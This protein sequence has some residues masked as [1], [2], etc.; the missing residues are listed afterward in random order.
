MG[1]FRDGRLLVE[2]WEPSSQNDSGTASA[3]RRHTDQAINAAFTLL[4]A[5]A[6]T[7]NLV[8]GGNANGLF[9]IGSTKFSAVGKVLLLAGC[10]RG[11]G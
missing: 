9:L 2:T 1:S 7:S 8:P 3:G 5:L 4:L 10:T 11:E 6:A